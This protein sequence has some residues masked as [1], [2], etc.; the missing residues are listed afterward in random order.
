MIADEP[1]PLC[2]KLCHIDSQAAA[3]QMDP[4]LIKMHDGI[5]QHRVAHRERC[6]ETFSLDPPP[7]PKNIVHFYSG[8]SDKVWT[9][10]GVM[11]CFLKYVSLAELT[12]THGKTSPSCDRN[13]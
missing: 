2:T 1:F 7:L 11:D 10:G 13:R 12:H 4:L 8:V 5:E 6:L 3:M 9:P